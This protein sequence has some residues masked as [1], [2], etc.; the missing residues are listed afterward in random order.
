M[1]SAGAVYGKTQAGNAEVMN[2]K[3]NLPPK[4]RTMLILIDGIKPALILREE[5]EALGAG[6]EFLD[7]LETLNLVK[8]VGSVGGAAESALATESE[9]PAVSAKTLAGLDNV[10]RFRLAKQ[11]M[12]ITVVNALGIRAFFFTLKLERCSTVDDLRALADTY[13]ETVA[14][15]SGSAE[16]DILARRL[17]ELL[18]SEMV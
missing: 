3:I 13:R 18:G 15:A 7:Q 10:A 4:L 5:A 2:R 6:A 9:I 12:N 17:R 8:R 16:A 14:K 11:F 1:I